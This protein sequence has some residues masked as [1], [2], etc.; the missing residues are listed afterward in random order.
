MR[1]CF[2]LLLA[3]AAFALAAPLPQSAY[4]VAND[5]Q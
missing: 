5:G 2:A 1:I 3:C 4:F